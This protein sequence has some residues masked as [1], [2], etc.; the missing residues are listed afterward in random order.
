MENYK[1][2]RTALTE[3]RDNYGFN[4]LD[5][6][7][8]R[9][10]L[11]RSEWNFSIANSIHKMLSKYGNHLNMLGYEHNQL[12]KASEKEIIKDTEIKSESVERS[13]EYKIANVCNETIFLTFKT[14]SKEDFDNLLNEI[15]GLPG[16]KWN[17]NIKRWTLP[18][19]KYSYDKLIELGFKVDSE[20]EE[21]KSDIINIPPEVKLYPFQEEGVKL[22][23]KFNGRALLADDMGLGKS[24]QSIVY[25]KMHPELRPALIIVPATL[26]L[27]WHRE[28]KKWMPEE[29]DSVQIVQGRQDSINDD[30]YKITIINYDILQSYVDL[31][32]E[33]N[34]KIMILDESHAIKNSKAM[35]TKIV[36][37]IS[38]KMDKIISI[39]GTP[40]TNRPIEFFTT[41]NMLDHKLFPNYYHF[42]MEFCG[43]NNG[44]WGL[45]FKGASNTDKLHKI[46]V[47]SFMIRR[48]KKD[49]LKE[50]PPKQRTV[51]P[52]EINNRREYNKAENDIIQYLHETEGVEIAQ[53]A[54]F[55]QVLVKFEKLKQLTIQGKKQQIFD[56]IDN[57]LESDQKLII[58]GVHH[59]AIDM[60]IEKYP[61]ISVKLDGRD[62]PNQKQKSVD[63]F[64][65]NPN[66]R[67]FIGNVNAAGVGI[68]LTA[69]S[70]VAFVELP[71]VPA[72]CDQ[73]EDRAHRI[74]Q[75]S[76]SV[77]IY[78][79]LG[80]NTIEERIG[81]VID[82]KRKVISAIMDGELPAQE[83][84]LIALMNHYRKNVK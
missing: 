78:Y 63:E 11:N 53:K 73:A 65:N 44:E 43:G 81:E 79:L 38:R 30:E 12:M 21:T 70:N 61:D 20:V 40:L 33:I 37:K 31:L 34:Y 48:L 10:M 52:I 76:D 3:I 57:F 83:N 14:K 46:L 71:W 72:L 59:S 8:A 51:I 4:K 24:A 64:Q 66:I 29:A 39:S 27:N 75:E 32:T 25:M 50:L 28:I 16:R 55:A 42:G 60:L 1:Q 41:L 7:F 54:I 69:S 49:V 18:T 36:K 6:E 68:T 22:L 67:L 74:G 13:K 5:N 26:K 15:K 35:R 58:F 77:N 80:S 82:E 62:S 17:S 84:M 47:N 45:D 56:W 2:L 23:E 9:S 19:N